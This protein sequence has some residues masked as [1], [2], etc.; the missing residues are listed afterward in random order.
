MY[1]CSP[2]I[3]DIEYVNAKE[4]NESD[5]DYVYDD[6]FKQKVNKNAS[7][8]H[9]PVEIYAGGRYQGSNDCSSPSLLSLTTLVMKRLLNS[10]CLSFSLALSLMSNI[11]PPAVAFFRGI[12]MHK[13]NNPTC[14]GKV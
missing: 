6:L 1:D 11:P 2:Q 14:F 8:V 3:G 10:V 12:L 5:P 13:L 9:I 7:S 4:V